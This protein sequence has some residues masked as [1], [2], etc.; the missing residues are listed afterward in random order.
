MTQLYDMEAIVKAG[1]ELGL[2]IEVGSDKPGLQIGKTHQTWDEFSGMAK[3]LFQTLNAKLGVPTTVYYEICFFG[4]GHPDEWNFYIE[5]SG[6]LTDEQVKQKLK[7]EFIGVDGLTLDLLDHI[8][9][10]Q[11]ISLEEY[12]ECRGLS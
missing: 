4:A 11:E 6:S 10:I 12:T 1:K 9:Y 8:A 3:T 7:G 2:K 5:N